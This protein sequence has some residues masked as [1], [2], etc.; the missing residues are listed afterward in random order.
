MLS[1]KNCPKEHL[2]AELMA[3]TDVQFGLIVLSSSLQSS[4]NATPDHTFKNLLHLSFVFYFYLIIKLAF[5]AQSICT[6]PY[7]FI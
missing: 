5:K 7:L 3:L 4:V 1:T 6:V 2:N